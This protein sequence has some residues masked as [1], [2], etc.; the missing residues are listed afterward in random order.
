M[1]CAMASSFCLLVAGCRCVMQPKHMCSGRKAAL[2]R[3]SC[4]RRIL[5]S[6]IL[7]IFVAKFMNFLRNPYSVRKVLNTRRKWQMNVIQI[8]RMSHFRQSEILGI[9]DD[10][11]SRYS[12]QPRSSHHLANQITEILGPER[13][14]HGHAP[15]AHD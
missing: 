8:L 6:E 2:G 14:R 1:T 7:E 4:W 3:S 12:A 9:R 10:R 13:E 11:G 15:V 5:K